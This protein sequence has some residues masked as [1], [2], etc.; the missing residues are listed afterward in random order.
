MRS[1]LIK[2]CHDLDM[3]GLVISED[4]EA[5]R[6]AGPGGLLQN[7]RRRQ[8]PWSVLYDTIRVEIPG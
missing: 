1:V 4:E 5:R 3:V 6:D 7:E 2:M 8:M